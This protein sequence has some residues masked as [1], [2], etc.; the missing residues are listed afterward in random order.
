MF[1]ECRLETVASLSSRGFRPQLEYP[2]LT[3][4]TD[5]LIQAVRN[6]A[7]EH[8]EQSQELQVLAAQIQAGNQEAVQAALSK[9]ALIFISSKMSIFSREG[10]NCIS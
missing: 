7:Q 6:L 10:H 2:V 8:P 3:V 5:Q 9:L 4:S 1:A